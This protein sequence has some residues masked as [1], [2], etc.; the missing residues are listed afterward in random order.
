MLLKSSL[1]Q[2][3]LRA[4]VILPWVFICIFSIYL[5]LR[6]IDLYP[7]SAVLAG[8]FPSSAL[9][10]WRLPNIPPN[11][12]QIPLDLPVEKL[13]LFEKNIKKWRRKHPQ[14]KHTLI[15]PPDA[16]EIIARLKADPNS[17][18]ALIVPILENIGR[19][20]MKSDILRYVLLALEGG[21]YTD[22]DTW[23]IKPV[24]QWVPAEYRAKTRLVLGIEWDR[25]ASE[26]KGHEISFAQFN[27][28]SCA[29]HPVYWSMLASIVAKVDAIRLERG[30]TTI[31]ELRF[32]DEDVGLITGPVGWA[33]AV[34]KELSAQAGEQITFMNVTLLQTPRLFGDVLIL[35][36]NSFATGQ[37][38]SGSTKGIS[39]EAL[40]KH[41]YGSMWINAS[42]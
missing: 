23:P 22:L 13:A 18:H 34:L 40:I 26:R 27:M 2:R 30:A 32:S 14:Y 39:P 41:E 5:F 24:G 16:K 38:H 7:F 29:G 25:G 15:Y 6:A 33:A 10:S 19:V 8:R 1:W 36:I 42:N 3:K 9:P 28:A 12:W 11:I 37:G 31:S 17:E 35:P 4:K 20:V 21:V